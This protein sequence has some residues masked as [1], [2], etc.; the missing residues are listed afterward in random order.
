MR[1]FITGAGL[2][3]TAIAE[4][5]APEH[6]VVL[7]DVVRPAAIP[8]GC[9]FVSGDICDYGAVHWSATG[10]S[11][12][13]H[14][15]ALHGIHLA[16]RSPQDFMAVNVVGTHN[17]LEAAV[18]AGV[19]RVVF[20]ST[21]GVIGAGARET[22]ASDGRP[23]LLDDTP[24]RPDD[25][26][27]LTK[28]L[29]EEMCEFFARVRGLEVVALRYGGVRQL[30]E[31]VAGSLTH[32]WATS[33]MLTDLEDV[34]AA[35]LLAMARS[36]IDRLAFNVLPCTGTEATR[37]CVDSTAAEVELGL[38][39]SWTPEKFLALATQSDRGDLA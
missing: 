15:A 24:S 27:G 28:M 13:F 3:G 23:R 31:K 19:G 7:F 11:G 5:L 20:S 4:R 25:I 30:V 21:A 2:I 33:G 18:A 16:E 37:L 22:A 38:A 34:V 8:D 6:E 35:N 39:F 9:E 29:C 1:Y 12:I 10:A 17:V 36:K 26:Y 32:D 14:T